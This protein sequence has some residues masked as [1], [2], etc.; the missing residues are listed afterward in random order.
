M[1]ARALKIFAAFYL[2]AGLLT[3]ALDIVS[4]AR[5]YPSDYYIISPSGESRFYT[6][7]FVAVMFDH[8]PFVLLLW[9]GMVSLEIGL[10]MGWVCK[11][12]EIGRC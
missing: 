9:P 3:W 4:E 1:I 11:S 7:Q 5:R 8:L 6:R 12:A 2:A 10:R